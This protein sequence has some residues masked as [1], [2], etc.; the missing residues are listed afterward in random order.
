MYGKFFPETNSV[1]LKGCY[2]PVYDAHST[3]TEVTDVTLVEDSMNKLKKD[4][5]NRAKMLK[6]RR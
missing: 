3:Q 4:F 1:L 6:E 2:L 5:D